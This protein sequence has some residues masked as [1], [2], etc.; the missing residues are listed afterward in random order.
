LQSEKGRRIDSTEEA[1][2]V[3]SSLKLAEG[4]AA[5]GAR[6]LLDLTG[7]KRHCGGNL[8]SQGKKSPGDLR[9]VRNP[10]KGAN[11]VKRQKT[12]RPKPSQKL[13]P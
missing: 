12:A 8:K 9:G 13:R 1:E 4:G 6:S 7:P 10:S 3:R 2:H 11:A 5:G